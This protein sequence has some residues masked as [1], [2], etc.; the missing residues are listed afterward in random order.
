MRRDAAAILALG[1][2]L[3]YAATGVWPLLSMR[4]FEAVTGPKTDKWLV[5][6]VGLLVLAVAIALSVG[7]WRRNVHLELGILA[8]SSCLFLAAIDAVYVA[9]RVIAKVY[10]VDAV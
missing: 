3:Y 8:I 5:K 1:Q 6:T 10:L 9:K 2:G 7:A 4:T